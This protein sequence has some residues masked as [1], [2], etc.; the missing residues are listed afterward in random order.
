M[1]PS[2]ATKPNGCLNT[3]NANATPI[4]PKGAVKATIATREKLCN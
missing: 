2:S 3:S 1:V 4:S